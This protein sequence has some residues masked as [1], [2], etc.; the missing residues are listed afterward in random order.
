[1]AIIYSRF[2]FRMSMK[3]FTSFFD[4][5]DICSRCPDFLEDSPHCH[6]TSKYH[7]GSWVTG[8][9]A[10]GAINYK[11]AKLKQKDFFYEKH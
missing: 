2:L 9:T 3:D 6:W 5:M 11:G 4:N 1:M 10:G 7:Y 8:S